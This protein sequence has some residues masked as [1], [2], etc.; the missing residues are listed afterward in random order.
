[1][2]ASE[3][4]LLNYST[5][6]CPFSCNPEQLKELEMSKAHFEL[7]VTEP[8]VTADAL[9]HTDFTRRL[10]HNCAGR[11]FNGPHGPSR[12][13]IS[14]ANLSL[15][16]KRRR[17]AEIPQGREP[18]TVGAGK[19]HDESHTDIHLKGLPNATRESQAAMHDLILHKKSIEEEEKSEH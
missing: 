2:I 18:Q 14:C 1:M 4:S 6:Y 13:L 16:R 19:L 3:E 11:R 9:A 12:M 10:R 7:I 8:H 5:N 17:G 15:Q